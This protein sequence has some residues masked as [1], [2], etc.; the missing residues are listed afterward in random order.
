VGRFRDVELDDVEL[1]GERV[2]LR[3]W[4]SADADR[5]YEIARGGAL[6]TFLALPAPYTR[7]HAQEFVD[8]LGHEGRGEGTGLG[9]A[10]VDRASGRVVGAAAMR[11]GTSDAG[12][13][14]IGYW[15]APDARGNGYA[16]EASRVL[17][18]FGHA[19]GLHRIHLDCDVRNVAS[20]RTALRAGFTFEG[21][22]RGSAATR[23]PQPC[24][25]ARFA[26]IAPDPDAPIGA[27]FPP[28]PGGAL[29]DGVLTLRITRADD[30]PGLI[31]T[32]DAESVRW[33]FDG[34]APSPARIADGAARAGL[35]WLVGGAAQLT[36]ADAQT[37]AVA[38]QLTLR[39]AGPPLVG[40][41][42]YGVH[43]AFRGRGFTARA[44]RLVADYAFGVAHF[45]RLE[46]GAKTA[47]IASQRAAI[48]GGFE[49]D[50]VRRA[51]LHNADGT[52][53]D[54]VRFALINPR[55]R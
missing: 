8:E 15:V 13:A 43:P 51:R 24:D 48:S 50:G 1:S 33:N 5:V 23:F 31:E 22:M 21:I 54:E 14:H 55:L 19:H 9:C 36:M 32:E 52:F 28:L 53:D 16:A 11:F 27:G 44:L 45:G 17:A 4:R 49:P 40:G 3:R 12:A 10:V 30:A 2:L 20:A 26:R 34:Q 41:I 25:V 46:L 47:N 18:R 42:G 38:G 35:M 37:G 7:A 39:R 6:H 29:S